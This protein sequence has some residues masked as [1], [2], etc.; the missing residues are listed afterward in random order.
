MKWWRSLS[1]KAVRAVCLALAIGGA[2]VAVAAPLTRVNVVLEP[3]V[4]PTEPIRRVLPGYLAA[5]LAKR[6]QDFPA[7]SRVEIVIREIYLTHDAGLSFGRTPDAVSG[8]TRVL[9]GRGKVLMEKRAFAAVSSESSRF[10]VEKDSR[11]V[12]AL[13]RALAYWVARDLSR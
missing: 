13:A 11:R 9:D 3:G 4:A 1:V 6:E 12:D 8:V 5:E 2:G 10:D 7:G